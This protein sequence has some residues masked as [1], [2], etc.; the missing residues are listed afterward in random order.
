MASQRP[1]AVDVSA[2]GLYPS[3]A[4]CIVLDN[5]ALRERFRTATV[6]YKEP[7]AAV[8]AVAKGCCGGL[9]GFESN[10]RPCSGSQVATH[11]LDSASGRLHGGRCVAA[12]HSGCRHCCLVISLVCSPG[13]Q[14]RVRAEHG[15]RQHARR[16]LSRRLRCSGGCLLLA[17]CS[18]HPLRSKEENLMRRSNY[19]EAIE[20]S[21]GEVHGQRVAAS[22]YPLP[23]HGCIVSHGCLVGCLSCPSDGGTRRALLP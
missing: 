17:R 8:P 20:D 9:S 3:G 2:Q 16:R 18:R 14:G 19:F 21:S 13:M 6:V 1:Q 11:Q 15:Q 12:K 4:G 5:A 7:P 23:V 10:A 22:R